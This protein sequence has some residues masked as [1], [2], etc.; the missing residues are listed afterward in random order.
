MKKVASSDFFYVNDHLPGETDRVLN[1][2]KTDEEYLDK[3]LCF[4]LQHMAR[5]S[6][7]LVSRSIQHQ[8]GSYP[9]VVLV[10]FDKKEAFLKSY[11]IHYREWSPEYAQRYEKQELHELVRNTDFTK[12]T[13]LI[14]A[15]EQWWSPDNMMYRYMQLRPEYESMLLKAHGESIPATIGKT[16]HYNDKTCYVCFKHHSKKRCGQCKHVIY[17]GRK[18]QKKDW[19]R[20]G[21]E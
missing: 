7:S 21:S 12:H 1:A 17:C 19:S 14:A 13:V 3:A 18:C 10:W 16:T 6:K 9:C 8:K 20:H 4:V 5:I 2:C 15:S 11:Q